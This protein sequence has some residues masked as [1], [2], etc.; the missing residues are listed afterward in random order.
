[1][2]AMARISAAHM[3][4]PF[5]IRPTRVRAANRTIAPWAKLNMPDALKISTKP[6]AT[7][8]YMTPVD[9]PTR[10]SS[11]KKYGSEYMST[12]GVTKTASRNSIY[13]FSFP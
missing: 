8:E 2:T 12:K 1:M 4:T 13:L 9:N 7:K 11:V 3:G 10:I 5:S 6:K